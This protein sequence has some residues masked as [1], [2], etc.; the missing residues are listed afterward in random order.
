MAGVTWDDAA[1]ER[2]YVVFDAWEDVDGIATYEDVGELA[3]V[4]GDTAK[5]WLCAP[6]KYDPYI[7]DVAVTRA[8]EG[9]RDVYRNLT[10]W[11]RN[12]FYRALNRLKGQMWP[13]DWS[14]HLETLR[15]K[16]GMTQSVINQAM[17]RYA[18]RL[19]S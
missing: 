4:S 14:D 11:E 13:V 12:E 2:C 19:G 9:D 10:V 6:E 5:R 7:D 15:R 3:G 1:H 18:E 8:L 17:L 16:L